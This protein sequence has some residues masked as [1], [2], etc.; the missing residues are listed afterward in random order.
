[1]PK[2]TVIIGSVRPGRVGLPVATWFAEQ[3]RAHAGFDVE[4]A[5][6][7]E[8]GLPFMDEPNHPRLQKYT[9]P[10]TR[11]WSEQI[12]STDAVVF[13]ASEYN[14]GYPPALKNAI[15][16]LHS[17]WHYKPAGIV[18][19]GGVSAGTRAAQQLKQV[20]G[21]LKMFTIYEGVNI[22]FVT[23]F[24]EDNVIVANDVM[25]QAVTT[26]L[27]EMLKVESALRP[28]RHPTRA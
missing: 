6:L 17:E 23:Q 20:L 24:L 2:L 26:M 4:V 1:M 28:L 7:L 16:Y 9:Q 18:S 10:H 12:A 15:D 3:A 21:A 27:D 22:P 11:A 14:F 8:I 25:Q 13:V 19:Y 5:D